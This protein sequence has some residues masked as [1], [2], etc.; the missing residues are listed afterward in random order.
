MQISPQLQ[1]FARTL[2]RALTP[3]LLLPIMLTSMTGA[4]HPM[5]RSAGVPKEQIKWM[6]RIHSGNFLIV[7]L[8]PVY[9]FLVGT[10]TLVL[11][12]T[13][14]LMLLRSSRRKVMA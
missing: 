11:A 5:L 7:D 2:H 3:I 10:S 8:K 9:P 14:L 12:I 4:L 6:I 13:G 1:R